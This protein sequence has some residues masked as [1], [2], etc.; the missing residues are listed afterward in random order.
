MTSA[1]KNGSEVSGPVYARLGERGLLGHW[2][3]G[4]RP[5]LLLLSSCLTM[6]TPAEL[7]IRRD[8]IHKT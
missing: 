8:N 3:M 4:A 5:L 2:G 1:Y 6:L 7:P